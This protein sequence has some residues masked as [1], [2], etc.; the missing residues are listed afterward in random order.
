VLG[1]IPLVLLASA[2]IV[3]C[4]DPELRDAEIVATHKRAGEDVENGW[5]GQED[6]PWHTA[7]DITATLGIG[8]GI[9]AVGP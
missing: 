9:A 7:G 1:G 8:A 3:I 5:R 4:C 6:Y 2:F